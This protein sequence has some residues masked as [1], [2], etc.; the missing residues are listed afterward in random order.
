METHSFDAIIFDLDGV[1]TNTASVHAS[2]WKTIFDEFLKSRKKKHEEPFK[3]FDKKYDYLTYVDGKPRYKG[4]A[5]FLESRNIDIPYGDPQDGPEKETVCGLGNKKN[6]AFREVLEQEGVDVFEST[7]SFIKDLR[8]AGIY[9]GV[10]SS[11]KN[12]KPILEVAKLLDYF[13][14][15]VDGVI[16]QELKLK[17]KPEPEIFTTACDQIGVSYDR[18]VVV[19]DAVSGVQ[20]GKNGRF[21]LTLGIARE[22]N[23]KELYQNGA[24]IVVTDIS[25]LGG[26]EAVEQWFQEGLAYDAWTLKYYTYE[27]EK[28]RTREALLTIGNGYLGSR[29]ALEETEANDV[30]YPGTY[31]AGLYNRM[32]T[33]ISG[34]TVSN[35]DFVNIPNW[36]SL[37][38][39][40]I[41]AASVP[42]ISPS[43]LISIKTKSILSTD[44]FT[45]AKATFCG[46]LTTIAPSTGVL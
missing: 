7:L 39:K 35:E 45:S 24:D 25:E 37:S 14:V 30:N 31:I 8:K 32:E 18:A 27:P 40:I 9:V 4:V 44:F 16:S 19:E 10:A 29:G 34:K 33:E 43:R 41:S 6:I 46:E 20:A 1:I 22:G 28:E 23:T 38:F 36:L 42:S 5:S 2:A 11:S 15:R 3:E 21:G 12:C 26:L 17:G 13:D